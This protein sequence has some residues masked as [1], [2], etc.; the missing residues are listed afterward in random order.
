MSYDEALQI[1][2]NT[3]GPQADRPSAS[4]SVYVNQVWYL[5]NVIGLLAKVGEQAGLFWPTR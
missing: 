1:Y 2:F 4:D 3:F 5:R